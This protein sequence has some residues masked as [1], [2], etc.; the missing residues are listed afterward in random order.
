MTGKFHRKAQENELSYQNIPQIMGSN[1]VVIDLKTLNVAC[2]ESNQS[3]RENVVH[4]ISKLNQQYNVLQ[5]PCRPNN[6]ICT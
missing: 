4:I 2:S 3:F 6:Y 1:R 5:I